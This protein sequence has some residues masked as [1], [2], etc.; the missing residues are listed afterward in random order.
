MDTAE[1]SPQPVKKPGPIIL[2]STD[3]VVVLL[4]AATGPS[5]KAV[6]KTLGAFLPENVRI[7]RKEDWPLGTQQTFPY[8]QLTPLPS[9]LV[10]N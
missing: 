4:N 10:S 2:Y 3:D 7:L 8:G 5:A 6:R 1:Q 9:S